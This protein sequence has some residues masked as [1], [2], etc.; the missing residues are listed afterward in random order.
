[1]GLK[2]PHDG[3]NAGEYSSWP[4]LSFGG[5]ATVGSGSC[6]TTCSVKSRC[7]FGQIQMI[8]KDDL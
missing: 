8:K 6:P 7:D 1:M 4:V 5:I 2:T 3:F